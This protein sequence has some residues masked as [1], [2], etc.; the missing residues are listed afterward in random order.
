MEKKE[1]RGSPKAD[2]LRQMR[3]QR[4]EETQRQA[5]EKKVKPDPLEEVGRYLAG[6]DPAPFEPAQA[7]SNPGEDEW[8][9]I[10]AEARKAKKGK[11]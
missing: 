11:R 10:E 2:W 1:K 9:D 5:R 8:R 7:Q 6:A 4:W 3:E